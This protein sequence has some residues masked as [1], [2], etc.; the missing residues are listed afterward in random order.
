M[1]CVHLQFLIGDDSK[2]EKNKEIKNLEVVETPD[3]S[4]SV[5][6]K[7]LEEKEFVINELT[8][9]I[10][11]LRAELNNAVSEINNLKKITSDLS[12]PYKSFNKEILL[13]NG[14]TIQ[15]KIIYQ[16]PTELRVETIIGTLTVDRNTII[17]VVEKSPLAP[18]TVEQAIAQ[19]QAAKAEY[20]YADNGFIGTLGVQS[21]NSQPINNSANLVL[22]G[23]IDEIKD[24]SGNT[25]LSG[26]I[27][28]IGTERADF[29]KVTFNIKKNWNG[30][31]KTMTAFAQGTYY[32][33]ES[34]VTA[35]SSVLPGASA[36]FELIIPSSFGP[37]IGYSYDIE[38]DEYQ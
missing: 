14:S 1:N 24:N 8:F 9:E 28:N 20:D 7:L 3:N 30:D 17:R 16:D 38:W 36:S 6:S 15:G 4:F 29:V 2:E 18:N 34:G 19:T 21:D 35:N 37:F 10:K 31:T 33:F 32:T 25:I 22:V 27:K 23:N 26:D 12:D 13:N 11:K 5:S